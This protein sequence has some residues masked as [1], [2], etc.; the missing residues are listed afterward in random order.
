MIEEG[1]FGYHYK[2]QSTLLPDRI[3]T[4]NVPVQKNHSKANAHYALKLDITKAYDRV[5]M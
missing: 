3:F 2:E 5:E 1:S 4:H